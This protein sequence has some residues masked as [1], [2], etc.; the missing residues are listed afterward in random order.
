MRTSDWVGGM[1]TRKLFLRRRHS[2]RRRGCLPLGQGPGRHC[3][4]VGEAE[5]DSAVKGISEVIG[6][7]NALR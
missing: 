6:V 4:I 5:F 2:T 3:A 1:S 7:I